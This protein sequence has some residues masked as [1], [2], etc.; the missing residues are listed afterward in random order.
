MQT[1]PT[2]GH[3]ATRIERAVESNTAKLITRFGVPV[4]IAI[5]G[6]IGGRMLN[7]IRDSQLRQADKQELQAQEMAT[8]KQDL[9]VL[10]AK[11]DYG[12]IAQMS[13]LQRRVQ[14]LEALNSPGRDRGE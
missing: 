4:L 5:L 1:A 3:E 13:E 8:V 14:R 11:L 2:D 6:G 10:N 12:V 7:D 9:K